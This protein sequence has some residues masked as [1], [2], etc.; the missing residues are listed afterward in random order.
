MNIALTLPRSC[1]S[2][3][4]SRTASAWTWSKA[5]A[6]RPI[7]SVA[8]TP[9]G[10]TPRLASGSADSAALGG[11]HPRGQ[12]DRRRPRARPPAAAAAG[13]PWTGR[14][15]RRD[16][17]QQEH[18]AGHRARRASP[19]RAPPA[20]ASGCAPRSAPATCSSIVAHPVDRV[21]HGVVP[22]VR[23]RGRGNDGRA[24]GAEVLDVLQVLRLADEV[25]EQLRGVHLGAGHGAEEGVLLGGRGGRLEG[26]QVGLLQ[27]RR[28]GQR[29]QSA[30]VGQRG[31]VV[32]RG[33][34][35]GGVEDRA[36]LRGLVLGP[37][38]RAEG[39]H[40]VR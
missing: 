8:S 2:V 20:G 3:P 29:L 39:A 1:A 27:S 7:S 38:D 16:Q 15:A 35:E 23:R 32:G 13:R 11:R 25:A 4:A 5:R 31:R 28:G 10:S 24:L 36:L 12:P 26:H 9:I 14:R 21:R 18:P 37:G 22:Q 19:T 30:G 6:T 34:D 17:H 33:L 40:L